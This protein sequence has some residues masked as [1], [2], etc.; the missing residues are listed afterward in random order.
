MVESSVFSTILIKHKGNR[1]LFHLTAFQAKRNKFKIIP[2]IKGCSR[3][4]KLQTICSDLRNN[5]YNEFY[6]TLK[7]QDRVKNRK[8]M[9]RSPLKI[10][11]KVLREIAADRL[12]LEVLG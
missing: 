9:I 1:K 11:Q 10:E 6:S 12:T 2:T 8:K 4:S 3:D 5:Y 7:S